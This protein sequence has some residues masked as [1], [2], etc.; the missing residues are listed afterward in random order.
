MRFLVFSPGDVQVQI[1]LLS[2]K[3]R[4]LWIQVLPDL[5]AIS[6]DGYKCDTYSALDRLCVVVML[7]ASMLDNKSQGISITVDAIYIALCCIC[8]LFFAL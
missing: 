1:S 3:R 5:L 6:K 4:L 8:G 2:N 7:N